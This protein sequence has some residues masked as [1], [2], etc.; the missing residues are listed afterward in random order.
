[1]HQ[2]LRGD[3]RHS[4]ALSLKALYSLIPLCDDLKRPASPNIGNCHPMNLSDV[5]IS[6]GLG[7]WTGTTSLLVLKL[8]CYHSGTAHLLTKNAVKIT[9]S[10]N[11]L[12]Y[13][14][15]N[16]PQWSGQPAQF[17]SSTEIDH[18]FFR[19]ET[20]ELSAYIW[21]VHCMKICIINTKLTV[22]YS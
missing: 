5:W 17:F 11:Y 10:Q 2:S 6:T 3:V 16:C 18:C 12:E 20:D 21:R 4:H 9:W 1:M 13:I 19:K 22:R 7:T 8:I 15:K 14:F